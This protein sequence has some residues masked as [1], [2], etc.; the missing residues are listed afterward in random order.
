MPIYALFT[1]ILIVYKPEEIY[2]VKFLAWGI[3]SIPHAIFMFFIISIVDLFNASEESYAMFDIMGMNYNNFVYFFIIV[4]LI[5]FSIFFI[6]FWCFGHYFVER[7]KRKMLQKELNRLRG[8]SQYP[9]R[10]EDLES[11]S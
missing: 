10:L 11:E 7:A 3:F 5:F 6:S 2:K 4:G 9:D 1:I 8:S